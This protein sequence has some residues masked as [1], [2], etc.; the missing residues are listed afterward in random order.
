MLFLAVVKAKTWWWFLT[1]RD[2]IRVN[3][4]CNDNTHKLDL[5]INTLDHLCKGVFPLG[6]V[7]I[8]TNKIISDKKNKI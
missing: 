5:F 1:I 8:K 2:I 6:R 3:V 4:A 7:V